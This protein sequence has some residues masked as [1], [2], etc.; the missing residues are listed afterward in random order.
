MKAKKAMAGCLMAVLLATQG[1]AVFAAE[2]SGEVTKPPEDTS[3]VVNGTYAE[4]GTP[5]TVYKVD[6]AWGSMEFTYTA[7]ANERVW[8][9]DTHEYTEPGYTGEWSC[10]EGAD[11][12][13]VTNHSNAAVEADF[14]Y[15]A[16]KDFENITGI[17]SNEKITLPTAEG[18]DVKAP[19]LTGTTKLKLAGALPRTAA[20][21]TNIGQI[22]VTINGTSGN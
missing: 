19:E 3:I 16:A 12:V 15:A 7:N 9:P 2:G 21:P 8:N 10:T 20:A 4:T 1:T 6:L 11:T 13:S 14:S 22:T 18:K 5:D 17:F